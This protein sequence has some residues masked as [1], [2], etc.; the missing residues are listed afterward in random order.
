M[1][2]LV[3]PMLDAE[4]AGV[5]FTLDPVRLLP[6]LLLVVSALGLG[7]GVVSGCVPSDTARLRRSDL[8]I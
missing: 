2:V 5:C 6:D 7:A 3:Q 1:A 4:C 8:G